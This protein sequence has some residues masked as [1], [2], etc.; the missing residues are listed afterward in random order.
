MRK[1]FFELIWILREA[2]SLRC[3]RFKIWN[4]TGGFGI[5]DGDLWG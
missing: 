1:A 2:V 3:V 5:S 4:R